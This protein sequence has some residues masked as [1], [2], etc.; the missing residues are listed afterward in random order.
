VLVF[1]LLFSQGQTG[2]LL[3]CPCWRSPSMSSFSLS[4]LCLTTAERIQPSTATV[5][6]SMTRFQFPDCAKMTNPWDLI[7]GRRNR[8]KFSH[9]SYQSACRAQPPHLRHRIHGRRERGTRLPNRTS[10]LCRFFFQPLDLLQVIRSV[11]RHHPHI[12]ANADWVIE[13]RITGRISASQRPSTASATSRWRGGLV[14][15]ARP[16]PR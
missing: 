1:E 8:S 7:V 15:R 14:H 5:M 12:V 10:G 3:V 11:F 9:C 4:L 2:G 6:K 16:V 13:F